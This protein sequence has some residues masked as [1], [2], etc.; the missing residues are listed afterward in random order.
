MII[1][2]ILTERNFTDKPH[3]QSTKVILDQGDSIN[4]TCTYQSNCDDIHTVWTKDK[5]NLLRYD[6]EKK[7]ENNTKSLT[8]T[9]KYARKSIPYYPYHCVMLEL[10]EFVTVDVDVKGKDKN[11]DLDH[12]WPLQTKFV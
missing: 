1:Q 12:A 3:V 8:Y 11:N 9:I 4:L 10:Q 6:K 7:S 2:E 5:V